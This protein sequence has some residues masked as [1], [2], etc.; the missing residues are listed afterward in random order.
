MTTHRHRTTRRT[1]LALAGSIGA[2]LAGHSA[3][4]ATLFYDG[5]NVNIGTNGNGASGGTAGTWSTAIANWDVGAVPHVAWSNSFADTASF[6]G[7]GAAVAV[8]GTVQVGTVSINANT[9]TFN[10][11]TIDFGSGGAGILDFNNTNSATIN[12]LLS[13]VVKIQATGG[14]G[15]LG[16]A[17][18]GFI[19]GANVGLTSTDLSLNSDQNSFVI[20]HAAA[21]GNN[22]AAV[23]LTKGVLNLGNN[24][25]PNNNVPIS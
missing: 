15:N 4:A 17:A 20:N 8:T 12:A 23:K 21:F 14:T 6:G 5:G 1:V 11:G 3:Q 22:G 10:T 25:A 19:N 24:A 16:T 13:G 18:S 9:Y 2:L 7:T